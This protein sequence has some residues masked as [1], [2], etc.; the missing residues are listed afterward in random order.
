MWKIDRTRTKV[1]RQA[2]KK[3]TT[4]LACAISTIGVNQ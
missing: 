2:V 4:K 3:K 1:N